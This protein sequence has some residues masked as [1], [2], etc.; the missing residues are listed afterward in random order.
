VFAFG[1][2]RRASFHTVEEEEEEAEAEAGASFNR[3][4]LSGR[5]LSMGHG[6]FS[7]A[8]FLRAKS[9]ELSAP[10]LSKGYNSLVGNLVE[11]TTREV[12]LGEADRRTPRSGDRWMGGGM[13]K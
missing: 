3:E 9:G 2:G 5:A 12:V 10:F 7:R 4:I 11:P 13:P 6:P 8:H 1:E